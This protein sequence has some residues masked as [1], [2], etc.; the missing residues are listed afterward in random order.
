M[1]WFFPDDEEAHDTWTYDEEIFELQLQQPPPELI[2]ETLTIQLKC[3]RITA[4]QMRGIPIRILNN[5]LDL[6]LFWIIGD[7]DEMV[8]F[9]LIFRHATLLQ[10]LTIFGYGFP[11]LFKMLPSSSSGGSLPHLTSFRL[12]YEL[13]SGEGFQDES[14]FF[15]LGFLRNRRHLRRLYLRVPLR[16]WSQSCDLWAMVQG[17]LALEVLGVHFGVV[18]IGEEELRSVVEQLPLMLQALHLAFHC[19]ASSLL[20]LV[21]FSCLTTRKSDV[22]Q[23]VDSI[24]KLPRLSFLHLYGIV[25]RLPILLEDLIAEGKALQM[26]GLN[27][28][29]WNIER[30]GSEITTNKWPRWKTKFSVA[31]DFSC[32]DD[33]WLFEYN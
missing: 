28:A 18:W 33:A 12:S 11:E 24:G 30:V 32:E 5:L 7:E 26:I 17:L 22:S 25:N 19:E 9:D 6:E 20:P 8:G 2:F 4:S 14:L 21:S 29:I 27:R 31:E 3:L 16:T 23:K 1:P 15:L 10:S 13:Y